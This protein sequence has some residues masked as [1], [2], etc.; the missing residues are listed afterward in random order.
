MYS[1]IVLWLEN[2]LLSCPVKTYAGLDCPGCGLQR[3]ILYLLKGD[4]EMSLRMHPAGIPLVFLGVFV[5]LHFKF[6]F[7]FGPRLLV[8]TYSLIAC[9]ILVNF[10][11]KL[12]YGMDY[13]LPH[14][15]H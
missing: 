12:L 5:L 1:T 6:K 9:I 3:S 2:H 8:A 11:F 13:L 10:V 4:L 15:Q 14:H 7:S